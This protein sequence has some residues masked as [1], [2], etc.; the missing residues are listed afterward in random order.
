MIVV[1]SLMRRRQDVPL[2]EF[3]RHW[4]DP[5]GP[6]VCKFPRLRHYTQNHVIE[7][8]AS[9]LR[10]RL[11]TDGFAELGY[12]NDGDQ[13]TATSSPEMAACDVDSPLF[14]GGVLRVVTEAREVVP[15][16]A[17]AEGMAKLITVFTG[18]DDTQARLVKFVAAVKQAAGVIGCIENL[19]LRQRGPRSEVPVLDV[20]VDAIIEAWFADQE[21]M[22]RAS[23]MLAE[24]A[25][26]HAVS[27]AV[28]E[29]PVHL[30]DQNETSALFD[31]G[32]TYNV[33]TSEGPPP[34]TSR[35][36]MQKSRGWWAFARHDG[37]RR[38]WWPYLYAATNR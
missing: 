8:P 22:Q 5:H 21:R 15:R 9:P 3:F 6:L 20:V 26:H 14:I 38:T 11:R 37:D 23:A 2:D 35:G 28:R 13:E 33:V 24:A 34:T 32:H 12:D 1:F 27:Y 4:L 16:P 29:I 10:D 18:G 36:R 17:P 19:P 30:R 31:D 25:G 7:A